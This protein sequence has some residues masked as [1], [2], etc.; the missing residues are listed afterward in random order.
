MKKIELAVMILLLAALLSAGSYLKNQVS[1]DKVKADGNLIVVD[2][3]HGENDPGKIGV[4]DVLEKDINLKIGKLLEKRLKKKGYKVVMTR[5]EDK[6]LADEGS[7]NRKAEDM[8]ARVALINKERPAL[9]VSVHQNSYHEA[10]VKGAQV[11]YYSHSAEGEAAATIMQKAL[12]NADP[13]N[14]RQAKSNE[15]YYLLKRTEVPTIIVECGFLSNPEEAELL[16][17]EEYQKK[18]ADA[19]AEGTEMYLNSSGFDTVHRSV[20]SL[21]R[22]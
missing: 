8:K 12:L 19:I 6:I 3:G 13:G 7:N 1:S 15:S 5:T 14:T 18:I 22:P 10:G 20:H 21:H 4:N 17:S 2:C 16:A 11:F 9:A